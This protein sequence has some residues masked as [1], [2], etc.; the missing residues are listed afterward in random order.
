MSNK[1]APL[2]IFSRK[3]VKN[4]GSLRVTIPKEIADALSIEQGQE[5]EIY[6]EGLDTIIVRKKKID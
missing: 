2:I 3:I 5:V 1:E 6:A 4:A